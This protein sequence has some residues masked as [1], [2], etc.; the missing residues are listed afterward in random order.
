LLVDTGSFFVLQM[1]GIKQLRAVKILVPLN[2]PNGL[3]AQINN[4]HLL[5]PLS[6]NVDHNRVC[7]TKVT[8]TQ[9]HSGLV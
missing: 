9:S 7:Q 4:I 1:G 6:S 8:S 5:V 3:R 2:N